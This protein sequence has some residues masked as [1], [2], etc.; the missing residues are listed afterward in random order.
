MT[1]LD[2]GIVIVNYNT[3]DLLR[4]CLQS[5]YAS[6]GLTLQVIVVDN[7][8]PDHSAQVVRDEFPQARLIVTEQN[9]GFAYANNKGLRVFQHEV[10]PR[11]RYVLLLNADTKLPPSAL[12]QM[13][14]FL[15]THPEAGAAGPKLVRQDGS[16]DLACRRSFP[17]MA[18][19]IYRR[20]ALHKLFPN[21]P[22]FARY[23]LSFVDPDET[24]VVDSVVGAFMMLRTAIMDQVGLLDEA[25]FMYGEDL[26]WAFRIKQADW[27]IYYYPAVVVL[28]Y[29]GE[30]SKQRVFKTTYEFY[31][32][33]YIFYRKHYARD[34]FILLRPVIVAG[35]VVQGGWAL[36]RN[37]LR[38]PMRRRVC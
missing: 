23:N 25:F 24:V 8:S 14:Q 15:D 28:H 17:D 7:C 34:T 33:M 18:T 2:L 9:G 1:S 26:D 20:M 19:L 21:H 37:A 32:A 27:L 16:L 13:V 38:A 3:A 5:I 11:P 4:E 35:I 6:T 29:K 31:R 12:A 22:R 10:T 36:L 30:S